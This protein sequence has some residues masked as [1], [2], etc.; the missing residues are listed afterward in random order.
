MKLIF[1]YI[2]LPLLGLFGTVNMVAQDSV[3]PVQDR[4]DGQIV[5]IEYTPDDTLLVSDLAG[6]SVS[7][8]RNFE[9][10]DEYIRYQKYKRYATKVY[11][12]AVEAIKIFREVEEVTKTMKKKKR[13]KHIKR[14]H[15]QL[16]KKFTEPLK[17]LSK[18]QGKI[19]IEMIEKELDTSF[20][21]LMKSLRG[22]FTA[23][24]WSTLSRIYGYRLKEKY[25]P[26]E[27][28]ILDAVLYDLDIS[29]KL[30]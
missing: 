29:H 18:T 2:I 20:Y 13:K 11:P 6:V 17:N 1:R 3:P 27:D 30:K 4:L 28:K 8:P 23:S 25:Q 15:K 21:D 9:D 22:G 26:G 16:K 24:Y 7:V 12:Y 19:L 10:A 5:S 14:L